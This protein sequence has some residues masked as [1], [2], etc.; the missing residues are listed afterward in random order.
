MVKSREEQIISIA[1]HLLLKMHAIAYITNSALRQ[2]AG[3]FEDYIELIGSRLDVP[4]FSTISRRLKTLNVR[5]IDH[6]KDKNNTNDIEIAVDS[7]G[8]NIYSALNH[9]KANADSRKYRHNDQVRK[10]HVAIDLDN[11]NILSFVYSSG[12]FPDH[13]ALRHLI[14]NIDGQRINSLRADGAYDKSECHKIC[15]ENYIKL[16][17]PPI[18]TAA[19]KK[20]D[21]FNKRNM[22]IK[23]ITSYQS[24]EEGVRAWKERA[25]YGKRSH[26]EGF[27]SR[28]KRIFGFSFNNKLEI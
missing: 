3:I 11:K 18:K 17:I 5:I 26:V 22:A 14:I 8:I 19:L 20:E 6:R 23:E 16:I 4:D 25:I 15:H 7:S 24:Y 27:F 2:T 1:M 28:F 13:L 10:M 12:V 21:H 9:S